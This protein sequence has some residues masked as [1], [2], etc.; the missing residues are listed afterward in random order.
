MLK[1]YL[2][3]IEQHINRIEVLL[4][5]SKSNLIHMYVSCGFHIVRLSPIVHGLDNW[6]LLVYLSIRL[7]F[8]LYISLSISLSIY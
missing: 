1:D 5:L 7:Y 2:L 6:Y 8:S 3:Y 4:L